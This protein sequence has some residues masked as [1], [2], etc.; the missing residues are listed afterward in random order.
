LCIVRSIEFFLVYLFER[1]HI[2][3][4]DKFMGVRYTRGLHVGQLV[5]YNAEVHSFMSVCRVEHII[6]SD[7]KI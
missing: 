2:F 3:C 4:L 5:S 6:T 7:R 1:I